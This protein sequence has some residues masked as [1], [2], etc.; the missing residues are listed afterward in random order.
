MVPKRVLVPDRLRRPPATGWSWVDRRFLRE[1]MAY[2][3][4]E[5]TLLYFIL[6]TVA[7]KHGMSFYGDG[8]LAAMVRVPLPALVSARDEL[9]ARDLIDHEVRFT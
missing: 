6:C 8:T 3:S 5:A 7:D 9:L 1:H 2:L 4:P